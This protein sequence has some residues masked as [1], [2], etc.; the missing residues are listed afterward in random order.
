M[1]FFKAKKIAP[2]PNRLIIIEYQILFESLVLTLFLIS[3]T[4]LFSSVDVLVIVSLLLLLLLIVLSN[5]EVLLVLGL[6]GV[7][8]VLGLS[9]VVGFVSILASL[10]GVADARAT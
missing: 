6:I 5:V 4:L 2:N 7:F 9:G 1:F 10:I 3:D 8:G